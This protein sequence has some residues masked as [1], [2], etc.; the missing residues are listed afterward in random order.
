MILCNVLNHP[1]YSENDFSDVTLHLDFPITGMCSKSEKLILRGWIVSIKEIFIILEINGKSQKLSL[2]SNR[3]DVKRKLSK[4]LNIDIPLTCGFSYDFNIETLKNIYIYIEIDGIK[5]PWKYIKTTQVENNF[6]DLIYSVLIDAKNTSQKEFNELN[7][8]SENIK[9]EYIDLV[10]SNTKTIH[11]ADDIKTITKL[12][13]FYLKRF[14][15]EINYPDFVIKAVNSILKHNTIKISNPWGEGQAELTYNFIYDHVNYLK[16]SID[17]E[18]FYIIQYVYSVDAIYFPKH[19]CFLKAFNS[20]V[21]IEHIKKIIDYILFNLKSSEDFNFNK[22][23]MKFKG[24]LMPDITPYHF[25]YDCLPAIECLN[26]YDLLDKIQSIYS[27]NAKEYFSLKKLYNLKHSKET[28]INAKELS[29]AL[30]T[31]NSFTF[32]TGISLNHFSDTFI[33]MLDKKLINKSLDLGQKK[34]LNETKEIKKA[35]LTIWLGIS[36]Q[37][38]SWNNQEEL[39]IRVINELALKYEK[40]VVIFDGMTKAIFQADDI[41]NDLIHEE[42]EILKRIKSSINKNVFSID[43][44]WKE[45]YEKIYFASLIDIFVVNYSTGSMYPS[46][47]LKKPGVTHLSNAMFKVVKD[48]HIHHNNI[49]KIPENAI[50][51]IPDPYNKRIDFISYT[52]DEKIFVNYVLNFIKK[53][54]LEKELI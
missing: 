43:L 30:I 48:M 10:L 52:I 18:D 41:D 25:F 7:L 34:F 27:L 16:F 54:N 40:I 46:R 28:H 29:K 51:D 20:H 39:L 5:K 37:K 24:L 15:N 42:K 38:R 8:L 23:S 1:L 36:A 19:N 4:N 33:E 21:G 3:D 50:T 6:L 9:R 44:V 31:E 26:E 22:E 14:I 35:N 11:N 2:N 32:L 47:M 45:S 53:N 49:V 12:E 17:K 13:N